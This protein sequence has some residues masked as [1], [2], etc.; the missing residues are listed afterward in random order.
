MCW[1]SAA[2]VGGRLSIALPFWVNFL[3]W[4]THS[5]LLVWSYSRTIKSLQW[6]QPFLY[7]SQAWP[8]SQGTEY[9]V[10]IFICVPCSP[11]ASKRYTMSRPVKAWNIGKATPISESV[12][13]RQ[14]DTNQDPEL[15]LSHERQ[16]T[17]S[18]S[19]HQ[20]QLT[21]QRCQ[22]TGLMLLP[23]LP[24]LCQLYFVVPLLHSI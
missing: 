12:K 20:R 4:L 19:H 16:G 2:C 14:G 18:S 5:W 1:I 24:H 17:R 13:H 15:W 23:E 11:L 10:D 7:G 8:S 21:V 22:S 9:W 3:A 6:P